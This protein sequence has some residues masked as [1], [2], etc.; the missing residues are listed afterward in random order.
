RIAEDEMISNGIVA[1]G[2]ICNNGLTIT[3]KKKGRLWYRNF[4]ESSGFPPSVAAERFQR[5]LDLY[6]A[7]ESNLANNSIIPHAPYSVSPALFQMINHFPGNATLSIHNQ[8]MADENLFFEDKQGDL[9]RMFEKMNI[10]I[11]FFKA[12]GKTSLQT[13][14]PYL[15]RFQ[16]MILVHNVA[17]S[18]EDIL[19]AK[20]Q[21]AIRNAQAFYCLCPNA[22]LYISNLLP[23]VNRFIRHDL[24]IVLGTDSLAS[25]DQLSILEEIKTLNKHFPAVELSRLFQ[26]ATINGAQALGCDKIFGSF[27]KGKKPGIIHL[28]KSETNNLLDGKIHRIV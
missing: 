17:C 19:F 7:F 11:S 16:S 3:Q 10:D 12:S 8:E 24:K 20:S 26:W 18:D 14:L 27:E 23:D 4:I 22:N 21:L 25:N 1:V 9:L 6:R 5:S 2:D 13:W 15:D 28:Q